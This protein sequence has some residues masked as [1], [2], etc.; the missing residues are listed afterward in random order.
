M[1]SNFA[2]DVGGGAGEAGRLDGLKNE[3]VLIAYIAQVL[4]VCVVVGSMVVAAVAVRW[5]RSV[6]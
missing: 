3:G 4:E 6:G 1:I 5:R 2:V